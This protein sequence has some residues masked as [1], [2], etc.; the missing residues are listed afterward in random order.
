MSCFGTKTFD[1]V[2]DVDSG[3]KYGGNKSVGCSDEAVVADLTKKFKQLLKISIKVNK[4]DKEMRD[5]I[6][7]VGEKGFIEMFEFDFNDF[8]EVERDSTKKRLECLAYISVTIM[9]S[10]LKEEMLAYKV[11]YSNGIKTSFDMSFFD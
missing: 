7:A 2:F 1:D 5:V 8:D 11:D 9:G 3:R 4:N 10:A 6:S